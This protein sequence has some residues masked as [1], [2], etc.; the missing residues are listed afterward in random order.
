MKSHDVDPNSLK[1]RSNSTV[2]EDRGTNDINILNETVYNIPYVDC[3]QRC[4]RDRNPAPPQHSEEIAG[5]RMPLEGLGVETGF[6]VCKES[7]LQEWSLLGFRDPQS[8][9]HCRPCSPAPPFPRCP[10]PS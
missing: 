9:V 8:L 10:D 7:Q 5:C 1:S 6:R 2:G 4:D 3:W